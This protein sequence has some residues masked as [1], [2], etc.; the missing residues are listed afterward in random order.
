MVIG[1]NISQF[2][3]FLHFNRARLTFPLVTSLVLSYMAAAGCNSPNCHAI[4]IL[5]SDWC[6]KS[7]FEKRSNKN[8]YRNTEKLISHSQELIEKLEL[9]ICCTYS[10]FLCR[11]AGSEKKKWIT[12][13]L[14]EEKVLTSLFLFKAESFTEKEA[15]SEDERFGI[16]KTGLKGKKIC[17]NP[18]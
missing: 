18:Y 12:C 1:W 6:K 16:M 9:W 17:F 11:N 4:N 14:K 5:N 10:L 3:I 13:S 8:T 2:L 7:I 15:G